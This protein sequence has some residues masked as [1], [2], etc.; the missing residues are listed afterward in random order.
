MI[1]GDY[2]QNFGIKWCYDVWP[3]FTAHKDG[4]TSIEIVEKY[5]CFATSSFDCCVYIWSFEKP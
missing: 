4:I 5:D 3:S 2:F 1:E